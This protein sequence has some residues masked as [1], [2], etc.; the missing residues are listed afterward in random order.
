MKPSEYF[1]RQ[2]TVAFDPGERTMGALTRLIGS[3]NMIWAFDFPHGDATYPGVVSALRAPT[4]DMADTAR[5]K[6]FGANA[7]TLDGLAA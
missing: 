1:L 5:A 4:A 6:L 2:G 3:D 7:R